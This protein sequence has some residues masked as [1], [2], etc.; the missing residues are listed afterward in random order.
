MEKDIRRRTLTTIIAKNDLNIL[1]Q[2][3]KIDNMMASIWVGE[4]EQ[5]CNGIVKDFS[6]LA[7]FLDTP[8]EKIKGVELSIF[9]CLEKNF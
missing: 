4:S 7:N 9:D 6:V 8:F 5:E 1:F 2:F 3:N